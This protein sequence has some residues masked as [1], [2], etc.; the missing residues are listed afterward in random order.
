MFSQVDGP[1]ALRAELAHSLSLSLQEITVEGPSGPTRARA[2]MVGTW[3]GKKGQVVVLVRH[4]R[5][6]KV[7]RYVFG[8]PILS[9][10]D[11]EYAVD[12]SF[13]FVEGMGF[14]LDSPDFAELPESEKRDRIASW[15]A[16]RRTARKVTKRPS[17][18]EK[19]ELARIP[20]LRRG[21]DGRL[22]PR[23]RLRTFF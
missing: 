14:R 13:A 17:K 10:A 11:L 23:T 22:D 16:L 12:S 1:T 6:Q 2:G 8:Q 7:I 4:L 21:A 18:R 9:I 20:L 3:N 5:P 19:A 15:N